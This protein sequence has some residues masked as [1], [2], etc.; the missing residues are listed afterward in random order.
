MTPDTLAALRRE[1]DVAE[2]DMLAARARLH[3]FV[4][5]FLRRTA[6]EAQLREAYQAHQE[7][8]VRAAEAFEAHLAARERRAS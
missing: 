6:T 8:E 1:R 5:F 3:A 4:G 7:A 2:E